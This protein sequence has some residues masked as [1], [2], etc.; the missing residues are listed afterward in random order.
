MRLGPGLSPAAS[1]RRT[2]RS[3]RP[4]AALALSLALAATFAAPALGAEAPEVETN[5]VHGYVTDTTAG[6][7]G[8]VNPHNSATTYRFQY[9]ETE[10]YGS[11]TADQLAEEGNLL[12]TVIGEAANLAPATEYHYRLV[13]ENGTG[14][15]I[16]GQD[17]TF[18]TKPTP[19][20]QG[21]C[22]NEAIRKEQGSTR[23]PECMAYELA[24]PLNTNGHDF[25]D[26]F[27]GPDGDHGW[28]RS[29][30]PAFPGQTTGN[31]VTAEV[32]RTEHGWRLHDYSQSAH[33][34]NTTFTAEAVSDDGATAILTSCDYSVLGCFG[35]LTIARSNPDFSL[36]P[37]LTYKRN[38]AVDLPPF[39][40]AATAD[41]SHVF[42]ASP[43]GNSPQL[44]EDTHTVGMGTYE[45]GPDDSL[46]YVI[47]DDD[48]NIL[49]CGG[50]LGNSR[51]SRVGSG[52]EQYGI[53]A[54]GSSVAFESPDPG[55]HDRGACPEPVDIYLRAN[56]QVVNVSAP[57]PGQQNYG[58]SRPDQ[59]ATFAG[60][61]ADGR[62]VFFATATRLA[63][64][65]ENE[66]VDLYQYNRDSDTVTALTN[67]AAVRI[68]A[69]ANV[70]VSP[71]GDY[72]Y[73]VAT[74][75]IG[76]HGAPGA[77]NL[78]LL[79]QGTIKFIAMVQA[80]SLGN[81]IKSLEATA[82]LTP[83]GRNLIFDSEDRVLT[84]QPGP[85]AA[86]PQILRYSVA[87]DSL[88]CISCPP[89][90]SEPGFPPKFA[91]RKAILNTRLQSDDGASIPFQTEASLLPEDTN[92]TLDVYLWHDGVL[93]LLSGGDAEV[94]SQ[95]RMISADGRTVFV[96]TF[97]RLIPSLDQ[98]SKKMFAV[99]VDGGFPEPT[100]PTP[101]SGESCRPPGPSPPSFTGASTPRFQGPANHRK[102]H[103]RYKRHHHKA[104][105][106]SAHRGHQAE[107]RHGKAGG[108][109][110]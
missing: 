46:E 110:R 36:T 68:N 16:A 73:F 99:R 24:S 108:G 72:V 106:R 41:L 53:S 12:E 74:N 79:H 26:G 25:S 35:P 85:Q 44:P 30:A 54:D 75:P 40:V 20:P 60:M 28:L 7:I 32:I 83:D 93:S 78:Y 76:G 10:A 43:S 69:V 64:G 84:H 22:P 50:V 14:G 101:C 42:F 94:Q 65:D 2:P 70:S 15:P 23:L 5:E 109:A 96:Q 21:E 45:I 81:E 67:G 61:S 107:P 11:Q 57:R 91:E 95:L 62:E 77:S 52:F 33:P 82:V 29:I 9:G 48:G 38:P 39:F 100:S 18:T 87:E 63:S 71:Q 55:E 6:F 19:A 86:T 34:G 27:L 89:N 56:G 4:L 104:K 17:R 66:A 49:P 47:R 97:E 51:D 3:R 105:H 31:G 103:K 80:A 58:G 59:G 1:A 13:A 102:R 92:G 88:S 98:D 37:L 90:G 8:T